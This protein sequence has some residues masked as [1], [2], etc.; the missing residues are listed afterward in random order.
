MSIHLTFTRAIPIFFII[1]TVLFLALLKLAERTNKNARIK[2]NI[3]NKVLSTILKLLYIT[4]L[5]GGVTTSLIEFRYT[6]MYNIVIITTPIVLILLLALGYE[7]KLMLA[8]AI[9]WHYMLI[10]PRMP[11]DL[12][13]ITEGVHM[14]RTMILYGKWIPELA[15]NPSYNPFPTMAFVRAALALITSIPWYSWFI[16]ITLIISTL[17]AYDLTIFILTSKLASSS[18]V[19]MLAIILTALTPYL[20]VTGHAH[21]VPANMMWLLS[22]YAMIL[23]IKYAKRKYIF[24]AI[25]L[26]FAAILTHPT[27]YI[28]ILLPLTLLLSLYIKR[29]INKDRDIS[30]KVS[31]IAFRQSIKIFIIAFFVLGSIRFAYEVGYVEYVGGSGIQAIKELLSRI[32]IG[33]GI[34]ASRVSLSLYDYGGVPFYQ[35]YLWSLSA[36]IAFALVLYH[37]LKRSIDI[38]QLLFSITAYIFIT[39]GYIM[40]VFIRNLPTSGLYRGA[41]PAFS[42]LIPLSAIAIRKILKAKCLIVAVI[43][44]LFLASSFTL[45]DPELSPRMAAKIRGIPERIKLVRATLADIIEAR[46]VMNFMEGFNIINNLKF[47]SENTI[48]FIRRTA[49]RGKLR[50]IYSDFKDAMYKL[51]YIYGYTKKDTLVVSINIVV[52]KEVPHIILNHNLIYNSKDNMIFT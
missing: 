9:M 8:T 7:S 4:V 49:L 31:A 28:E 42:L 14:T 2:V 23:V 17:I 25:L 19:G 16:F 43:I 6:T 46:T 3:S 34:E 50:V 41:Y 38:Y 20:L 44:I 22:T 35:A 18:S 32:F 47:Y 24:L 39:T 37:L 26:F 11:K 13:S 48:C 36:A 10:A 1:Q 21:Q 33:E 40:G 30:E 12:I 15:H 29:I 45:N 51:L 5:I 27:A 52:P